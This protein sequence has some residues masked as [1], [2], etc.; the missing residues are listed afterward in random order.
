MRHVGHVEIVRSV[1]GVPIRLTGERWSHI[2]ENNDDLAGRMDEVL[3][4]IADPVWVSRGYGGALVA[5]RSHGQ[6]RWLGV[7]YREV[8]KQD[9]FVLTAFITRKPT[10]TPKL[11]P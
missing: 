7:F 4:T 10:R 9:G 8:G 6:G 5:W 1:N 2:V 11:W 3:D